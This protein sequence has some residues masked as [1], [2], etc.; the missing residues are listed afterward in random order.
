MINIDRVLLLGS[1]PNS[2]IARQ[3][4]AHNFDRIVAINNAW[5]VRDDWDDLIYP[6]DMLTERLPTFVSKEQNLIDESD[7]VPAQ[8][9]YGGFIYAGGTM[10]FTAA[11][12]I[13]KHYKPKQIAF[14]GCDMLY[15]K[16]GPTHFYGTGEPDPLRED[17]SLT[18]LEACSARFYTLALQQGCESVNL[19]ELPSR[20]IFPRATQKRSLLSSQMYTLNQEKITSAL[21]LEAELGYFVL[22][23]RY[24][25]VSSLIDKKQMKKLDEMWLSAVPDALTCHL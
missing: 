19:S 4:D 17:I 15:P 16:Q 2:V 10:A 24:W 5:Q 7:F 21:A 18:S 11:Y 20:L 14:M 6:H 12:W 1:A 22:S 13:L 3:W 9:E 8:N 25:K 23:G